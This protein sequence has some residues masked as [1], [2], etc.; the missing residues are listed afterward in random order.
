[1]TLAYTMLQ[2]TLKL[3]L[4]PELTLAGSEENFIVVDLTA[5]PY[6]GGWHCIALFIQD[7]TLS[8]DLTVTAYANS[9]ANGGGTD[10]QIQTATLPTAGA[11]GILE[12]KPELVAHLVDRE[13][14]PIDVKSLVFK[15]NGTASDTISGA[16]LAKVME[17]SS[18]T[19]LNENDL[20]SIT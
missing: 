11:E 3:D 10:V 15:V 7:V 8:G 6:A 12:I 20:T 19:T 16:T 2:S 14:S 17:E 18:P 4:I 1:M 9:D 5:A 13:T